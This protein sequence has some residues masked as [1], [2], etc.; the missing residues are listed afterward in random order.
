M[1]ACGERFRQSGGRVMGY[2]RALLLACLLALAA[3]TAVGCHTVEGMAEDLE[4]VGDAIQD[5]LD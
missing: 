2:V 3:M 1:T 4:Q 5:A